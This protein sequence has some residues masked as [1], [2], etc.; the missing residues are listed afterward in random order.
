MSRMIFQQLG[1]ILLSILF[2]ATLYL[3]IWIGAL[4]FGFVL[5]WIIFGI[6]SIRY[7][8]FIRSVC[9][10]SGLKREIVISFD[11]G[12]F[13]NTIKV[14]DALKKNNAKACF[15]LTGKQVEKYPEIAKRIAQEGHLIGNHTYSHKVKSLFC[16]SAGYQNEIEK[17]N[18]IIYRVTGIECKYFRFPFGVTQPI[19]AY[20]VK[21]KR[22]VSMGWS[23]RSLDT[24]SKDNS[25][26][27]RRIQKK[28]RPGYI[29]LLHDQLPQTIDILEGLFE[30]TVK[31]KIKCVIPNL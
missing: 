27:I 31:N 17:T 23:I 12:P 10:L 3:S 2:L 1:I 4:I 19:N 26:V 25:A 9:K 24:L 13:P 30:Y 18:E 21:Q 6:F 29:L 22:L 20:V 5:I 14:L 16:G 15:F 8:P 11:D 7:S 28:W